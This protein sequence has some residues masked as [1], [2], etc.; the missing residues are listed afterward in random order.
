MRVP[1]VVLFG[2]WL[3]IVEVNGRWCRAPAVCQAPLR[4][5]Y[6]VAAL[7][8]NGPLRHVLVLRALYG[9]EH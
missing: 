3:I 2:R 6:I 1:V 8:F 9:W 7:I 5:P 4:A